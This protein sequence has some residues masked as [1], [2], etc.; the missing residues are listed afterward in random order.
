MPT[1]HVH[2]KTFPLT[3]EDASSLVYDDIIYLDDTHGEPHF[4]INPEL[5]EFFALEAS[6]Y[7]YGTEELT[8]QR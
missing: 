3:D 1:L 4:H 8:C 6:V 2:D 5:P 7:E